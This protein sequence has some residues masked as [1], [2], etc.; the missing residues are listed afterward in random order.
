M[1]NKTGDNLENAHV[2]Y[3]QPSNLANVDASIYEWVNNHLNISV[4]T[5]EGFK[6]APVIWASAERAFQIKNQK[7]LHDSD[8]ALVY[9]LVTVGRTGFVKDRTRKGVVYAPIPE[10][11]DYR[12]GAFKISREL[13]Q[14]KTANF[15]NL[16][17]WK[18]SSPR[19]I[20]FVLP[21]QRKKRVY[22]TITVPI[23]VYIDVSYEIQLR[24]YYQQQMNEMVT[25]FITNMGGL[26]YFPLRRNGHFYEAFVQNDFSTDNN[27]FSMGEEERTFQ[28]KIEIK[29]LAYLIGEDSNEAQPYDVVREN[30]AEI[31]ITRE[32]PMVG[33]K[34]ES[35]FVTEKYRGL[36]Q[37]PDG[38]KS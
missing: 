29:V 32:K 27:V 13:N 23:P 8:G 7:E 28:T 14:N 16:D 19:Q 35:T 17:A 34:P 3:L 5:H 25:P 37:N 6:K 26:N 24:S 20:N 30:P 1:H 31:R 12:G 38:L 36:G 4:T 21:K 9:P 10:N 22:N 11:P 2:I 33:E 15:S 18:T